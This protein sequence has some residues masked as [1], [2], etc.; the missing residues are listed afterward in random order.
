MFRHGL[1][2]LFAVALVTVAGAASAQTHRFALPA[3]CEAFLTVQSRECSVA[4]FWR[5]KDTPKGEFTA[6]TFGPNGMESAMRYSASYQWLDSIYTWDQSREVFTPPATDPIDSAE[7][8]NNGVD[9]YKFK[10]QRTAPGKSYVIRVSGADRL[11]GETTVIDG[12]TLDKLH[13]QLEIIAADGSVEYKSRGTQYYSRKLGQFFLGPETVFGAD[14]EQTEYDGSPVDII[15][16][17]EPGF[18]NITPLFECDGQDAALTAPARP[19]RQPHADKETDH[20]R[21]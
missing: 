19:D 8:L 9:T 13:T 17:G 6:A 18:G 4:L 10:M 16:P 21:I 3:Q 20:D 11:T 14:G 15:L 7:L 5:C 2:Y 1:T 12:F